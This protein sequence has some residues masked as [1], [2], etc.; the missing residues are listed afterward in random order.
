MCLSPRRFAPPGV[1]LIE[2]PFGAAATLVTLIG[3][4]LIFSGVSDLTVLMLLAR[5][6]KTFRKARSAAGQA[7]LH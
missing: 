7:S 4:G 6:T 5:R 1:A 2:N 3:I